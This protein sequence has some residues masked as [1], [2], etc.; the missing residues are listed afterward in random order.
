MHSSFPW[1]ATRR[2]TWPRRC[3]ASPGQTPFMEA[4][5]AHPSGLR[6]LAAPDEISDVDFL[7]SDQ[8]DALIT[9]LKRDF[10]TTLVDLPP[11][12]TGWSTAVLGQ[13]DRLVL[14]TKLTV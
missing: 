6:L 5:G 3:A 7:R 13:A 14:V 4:L 11:F 12:W 2:R 10:K 1:P 8:I 9:G